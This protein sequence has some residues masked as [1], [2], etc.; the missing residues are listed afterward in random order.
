M[1]VVDTPK[2][3]ELF[4]LKSLKAALK[5]EMTGMRRN[6]RSAS[7]ILKERYHL[8]YHIPRKEVLVRLENEIQ[9][10]E[11]TME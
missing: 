10:I 6:G 3:I 11:E 2:G 5:C 1:V 8:P 4:R 9:S 7:V